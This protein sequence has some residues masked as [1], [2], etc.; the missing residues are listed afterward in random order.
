MLYAFRTLNHCRVF[1]PHLRHFVE[2]FKRFPTTIGSLFDS[3]M[4]Q[5]SDAFSADFE[6]VLA[7]LAH[8][9]VGNVRIRTLHHRRISLPLQYC[10]IE[11]FNSFTMTIGSIS[12]VPELQ[13]SDP[14]KALQTRR[15]II[16]SH[17]RTNSKTR[18]E[19]ENSSIQQCQKLEKYVRYLE[20]SVRH[21]VPIKKL[22]HMSEKLLLTRFNL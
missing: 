14:L 16:E 22:S 21:D 8:S 2:H 4:M 9:G 7:V 19:N 17:S 3:T 6:R 11:I 18:V 5:T 1:L 20:K 12:E 10:W 15:D 13:S